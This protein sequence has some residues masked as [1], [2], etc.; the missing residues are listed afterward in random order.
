MNFLSQQKREVFSYQMT[1][2]ICVA[3]PALIL[4][5][6]ASTSFLPIFDLDPSS[7][8]HWDPDWEKEIILNCF[9]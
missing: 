3:D 4:E 5:A 1:H 2:F 7:L 9:L 6:P 8:A